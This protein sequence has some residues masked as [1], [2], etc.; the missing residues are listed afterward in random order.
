MNLGARIKSWF[1]K[2]AEGSY[3]GPATGWSYWGNPF[4]VP[5]GDGFQSGL[6]LSK[7]TTKNIPTVYACVMAVSKA[8]SLCYPQHMVPDDDEETLEKSTTSPASRVL[9]KPNSYQTWPQFIL[10]VI[11]T[12]LFDGESFVLIVR[13]ERYAVKALHQMNNANC[14]PYVEP[15]TGEVF[16]SVGDNPM[17]PQ[18]T[19]YM[20]PARDMI[21]FRQYCPRHPLVGE[22]A[23]AAAALAA[24]VNVALSANQAAFYNNMSRPSG[25]LST[26]AVLTKDQLAQLR[27]AFDE[28]SKDMAA[29]KIPVLGGGMKFSAMGISSQDAQL[30]EAQRM[31]IEEI[32]RVFGV[33][34]PVIGDLSHGNLSNTEAT[35]NFWLAT[36]LGSTIEN[37]ERSFDAAFNLPA[38]EYIELD[39]T[40]LLRM[41]FTARVEGYTK[42]IQGGL[43]APNE[44]R[45]KEGLPDVEGG[46]DVFLQQQMVS[47]S[48][49]EQ[50][51]VSQMNSQLGGGADTTGGG[52][53][54]T[55]GGGADTTDGGD[56]TDTEDA[57]SQARAVVIDMFKRKRA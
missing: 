17:L 29:G 18:M 30:V 9:R 5:F 54:T 39:V 43:I 19:S 15:T 21:H 28:Q 33:P 12:M 1:T 4:P 24:G 16:Y 48:L 23:I 36:G 55:D 31:S 41:D 26:D 40:A 51:H 34:L 22:S 49:L 50:L 46:D 3:R 44:A 8:I 52:A 10:N 32:A 35:I 37:V 2:G 20:V 45:E 57:A 13:D 14:T 27:A 6:T 7:A 56:A 53:D 47:V 38:T 25:I 11:A 42:A